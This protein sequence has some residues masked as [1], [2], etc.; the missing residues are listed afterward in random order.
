MNKWNFF[1]KITAIILGGFWGF[2]A[3]FA[4]TNGITAYEYLISFVIVMIIFS[5]LTYFIMKDKKTSNKE[6]IKKELREDSIWAIA[7]LI[8]GFFIPKLFGW[9]FS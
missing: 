3:E 5:I 9:V 8:I 7:S 4:S 6:L 2:R 1:R